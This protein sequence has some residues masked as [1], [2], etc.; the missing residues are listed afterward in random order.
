M[1]I[2]EGNLHAPNARVAVVVSRFNE[3]V[4]ERLLAGALRGFNQTGVPEG[5]VDVAWV[6][7]A[8]ELPV[9]AQAHAATGRYDAIV[10]LG[11]VIRGSTDHYD[12]VCNMVASGINR[13][14]L[15]HNLPV[16][17]GVL[18]TDT[19]DQA[20][21]RAG[22]KAGNKGTEAAHAA[23]EMINVLAAVRHDP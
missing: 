6:P 4:T 1:T 18:T 9:A 13:V 14:A 17:F 16:M 21:E 15:D 20:L 2:R 23:V 10:A 22:S 11:A 5:N 19:L 3:L 7:G 12:H 8:V